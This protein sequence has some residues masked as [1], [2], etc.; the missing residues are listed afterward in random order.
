MRPLVVMP[1]YNEAGN[2]TQMLAALMDCPAQTEVLIVDDDSPDG[3]GKLVAE[4]AERSPGR[5][6]LLSRNEKTG[7]GAAYCAGFK[8]ALERGYD[9]I[10]QMDADG[11]HPVDRL[12][13]L[14]HALEAGADVAVGSRYV[15]GGSISN[16]P[17]R[18]RLLSRFSNWYARN[19]LGVSQ[20]DLTGAY[21]AWRRDALITTNFGCLKASGYG[22]LIE[23]ALS[24]H[25]QH[26]SFVEVPITFTDRTIGRSKMSGAIAF[27]A[28]CMVVRLRQEAP[29]GN[30]RS[31]QRGQT[32]MPVPTSRAA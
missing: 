24:G 8:W 17:L 26:L 30:A 19:L 27:E 14:I 4:A 28:M 32:A 2:V 23:L 5:I 29:A 6:H 20:R 7:L 13:A 31:L 25:R 11:S 9:P 16:W 18:R 10:I 12:P 21:R 1:T 3:T 15:P 22:F